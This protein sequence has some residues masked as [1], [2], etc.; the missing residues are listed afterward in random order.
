MFTNIQKELTLATQL[1]ENFQKTSSYL[2]Q[3]LK[4]THTRLVTAEEGRKRDQ[5]E[6][7]KL[8]EQL[9]LIKREY[10]FYKELSEKL[11]F[12]QTDEL[13]SLNNSVRKMVENEKDYKMKIEILEQ[14]NKEC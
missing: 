5:S 7:K 3:K 2:D 6:I 14:E 1:K 13:Q 8:T 9:N 4:D 10:Q 12:R 11:E